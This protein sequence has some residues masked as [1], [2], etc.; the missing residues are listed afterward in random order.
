MGALA[1]PVSHFCRGAGRR[2]RALAH[3]DAGDAVGVIEQK[4]H[5]LYFGLLVAF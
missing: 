2:K 3:H 1:V 4:S 5:F